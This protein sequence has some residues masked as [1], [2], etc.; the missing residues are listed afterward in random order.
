MWCLA[1]DHDALPDEATVSRTHEH[2]NRR[3]H[4]NKIK[5]K[6]AY[7]R[8][9]MSIEQVWEYFEQRHN[10]LNNILH[11][12]N[13]TLDVK[14]EIC[15]RVLKTNVAEDVKQ[16]ALEHIIEQ[17][18][19]YFKQVQDKST[20]LNNILR[21]PKLTSDV[22]R[23]ICIRALNTD[24]AEDVKQLALEH[25]LDD[26]NVKELDLSEFSEVQW[27]ADILNE[28]LQ[29][30]LRRILY[31][32]AITNKLLS[33]A[34]LT[35]ADP[36]GVFLKWWEQ[37]QLDKPVHIDTQDNIR[38][39][40][41]EYV[42]QVLK[43]KEVIAFPLTSWSEFKTSTAIQPV[44][45]NTT[46]NIYVFMN[47]EEFRKKVV[48]IWLEYGK[49]EACSM[50]IRH[51]EY[52]LSLTPDLGKKLKN[53]TKTWEIP[54][55]WPMFRYAIIGSYDTGSFPSPHVMQHMT[56]RQDPEV[57]Q[58][59]ELLK[60]FLRV[61]H[62]K[63]FMK[64]NESNDCLALRIRWYHGIRG[65][66]KTEMPTCWCADLSNTTFIMDDTKIVCMDPEELQ[67]LVGH[68]FTRRRSPFDRSDSESKT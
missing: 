61:L 4:S 20:A 8:T 17:V 35:Q 65:W 11:D 28:H 15:I 18:W 53:T 5:Y 1:Q 26:P 50:Y 64:G 67:W 27:V 51:V 2:G 47:D 37:L 29:P 46:E 10:E 31:N 19:G 66:T 48:A 22:K 6:P 3:G 54:T 63:Q 62:N 33:N 44:V 30:R 58:G 57:S 41:W 42:K 7:D 43:Q 38:V 9:H 23:E 34:N 39:R 32:D 16:L 59:P 40:V 24:V 12:P 52:G 21:D 25:L 36:M 45:N 13:L 60:V 55:N 14:R 49:W 68:F 56:V